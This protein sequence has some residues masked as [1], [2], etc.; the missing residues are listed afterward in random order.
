MAIEWARRIGDTH[1]EGEALE[2]LADILYHLSRFAEAMDCLERAIRIYR[3]A[4]NWER[5]AWAIAQI[6]RA[7][8][9]LGL[10]EVSM[11]RLEEFFTTLATVAD[12]RDGESEPH[13]SETGA[14]EE[15]AE[16]AAS[17]LTPKTA[18]RVYLCLTTRLLFLGRTD[19]VYEPSERTIQHARVAGDLRIESL[20]YAFRSRAQQAQGKMEAFSVSATLAHQRALAS[21]DLEALYMALGGIA[22]LHEL[23]AEPRCA[24]DACVRIL[25][26]TTQLGNASYVAETLCNLAYFDIILGEWDNA[27]RQLEQARAMQGESP[28]DNLSAPALGLAL[29]GALRDPVS[30]DTLAHAERASGALIQWISV[31]AIMTLAEL[32]ILA[33]HADAAAAGLRRIIEQGE[34]DPLYRRYLYPPLAWAELEL[35]DYPGAAETLGEARRQADV[36]QYRAALMDIKRVEA[37]LALREGRW[38]EARKALEQSLAICTEAP[39]PYAEAKAHYVYGQ[40]HEAMGALALAREEYGRGLAICDRLGE[41]PY[42]ARI[43]EALKEPPV[44]G[45]DGATER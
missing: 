9:P 29:L 10:A 1:R 38:E 20:A 23:R 24:R 25:E 35:G 3:D 13:R 43:E 45:G 14:L 31:W 18:A 16:R 7:G 5:L 37:L 27:A 8:D 41:R 17:L 12:S 39:Y 2:K 34:A 33:G 21:G 36:Y 42:R 19:E 40:F 26:A 22:N 6:S 15:R 11:A 28:S 44:D 30:A 4:R 32:D